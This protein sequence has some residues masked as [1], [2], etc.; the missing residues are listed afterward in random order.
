MTARTAPRRT[1]TA[2]AATL[3][4]VALAWPADATTAPTAPPTAPPTTTPAE[5]AASEAPA[6]PVLGLAEDERPTVPPN[7]GGWPAPPRVTAASMLLLDVDGGTVLAA[8]DADRLRSVASTVKILTALTARRVEPD[9]DRVVTAGPEVRG[10]EGSGVGLQQGESW[11]LRQLLEGMLVRS[12]NDAAATVAA[13]LVP[14]G[15]EAFLA[16]MR[17]DAERLGLD[18]AVLVSPSGLDDR[19][20]LTAAHLATVAVELLADPVLAEIVAAD[21][22]RLPDIGGLPNRN[23]LV[24]RDSTVVGV[25]TGFTEAA[26][27]GLVAAA[28]REGRLLVAVVLASADAESRFDEAARLFDHAEEFASLPLLAEVELGCAGRDVVLRPDATSVVVP[29]ATRDLVDVS[30]P[31]RSCPT[32]DSLIVTPTLQRLPLSPVTVTV[33]ATAPPATPDPDA[34]VGRWLAD[35]VQQAMRAV[36]PRERLDTAVA[37]Q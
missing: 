28:R 13:Q 15:T 23:E 31:P 4:L 24:R 8:R 12:G 14:G 2:A 18:G 32:D 21:G 16:E 35:T 6:A 34:A 17:A 7:V 20:Q 29:E 10:L 19:N 27:Y 1:R 33:E 37:S 26:G 25:K 36:P 9:L 5:G 11:T 22:V 3:L 30:W